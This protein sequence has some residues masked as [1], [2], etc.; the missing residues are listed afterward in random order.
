MNLADEVE[1]YLREVAE[2]ERTRRALLAARPS[3]WPTIV[4]CPSIRYSPRSQVW[5]RACGRCTHQ[6]VVMPATRL[7]A[8]PESA[9]LCPRDEG[10]R[11]VIWP[12]R[13]WGS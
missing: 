9:H 1:E 7:L 10:G 12:A 11:S 6:Q 3:G 4:E 8:F 13:R 2:G 5:R